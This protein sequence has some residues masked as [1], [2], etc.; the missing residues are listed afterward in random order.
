MIKVMDRRKEGGNAW[1][2]LLYPKTVKSKE[3]STYTYFLRL[4]I[5]LFHQLI[6]INYVIIM[7][8]NYSS[9]FDAEVSHTIWI[10]NLFI[11][12]SF[13]IDIISCNIYINP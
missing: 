13:A 3:F 9:A 12:I 6:C 11:E 4:Y 2:K 5:Q 1:T 7:N 10:V 8:S